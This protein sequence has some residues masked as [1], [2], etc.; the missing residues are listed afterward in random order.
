[1]GVLALRRGLALAAFLAT[2]L[3]AVSAF[4]RG[5]VKL[6]YSHPPG[7]AACPDERAFRALVT[8]Q[9]GYDPFDD[10]SST[11]VE[12]QI[13]RAGQRLRGRLLVHRAGNTEGERVLDGQNDCANVA[14]ALALTAAVAIDTL[15]TPPEPRPTSPDPPS[16]VPK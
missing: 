12:A 4:S 6:T 14:A 16:P 15:E 11:R 13:E 1:M 10:T 7:D 9:L 3:T 2:C 8:A 5:A